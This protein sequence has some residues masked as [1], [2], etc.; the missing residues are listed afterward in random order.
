MAILQWLECL[1][2]SGA[3]IWVVEEMRR[4]ELI[5][6]K[7]E[8]DDEPAS[9]NEKHWKAFC[10]R[11][12]P[13]GKASLFIDG[14]AD[15][16]QDF[17]NF[18]SSADLFVNFSGQWERLEW[19][20]SCPRRVYLD[21]DPAYTQVWAEAYGCDMN[22]KGH[23][24]HLTVGLGL[25][26]KNS[27]IP[28]CGMDWKT[29]PPPACVSLWDRLKEVSNSCL[30]EI[31]SQ[32]LDAWTTITHW[33]GYG[34]VAWNGSALRDKRASLIRLVGLPRMVPESCLGIASDIQ[35][36]W[37]DFEAFETGGWK[38]WSNRLVCDTLENYVAYVSRSRGELG[39]AK[40]GYIITRSG[41][42]SDRSMGYLS[43]GNPVLL[44]DTGWQETY[45]TQK[46][47]V[48]FRDAEDLAEKIREVEDHLPEH[49]LE[50][51]RLAETTFSARAVWEKLWGHVF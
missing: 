49:R 4:D 24:H 1:R 33:H 50:A 21:V 43:C 47:L 14:T 26:P 29:V 30:A 9:L 25:T 17:Q 38:L 13:D 6:E 10:D 22:F 32:S 40:E 15:N 20:M 28:W 36:G 11:W 37:E 31:H 42:M 19:M 46:G 12:I 44:Q 3:E 48:C 18:V 16:I 5:Y 41:W 23:T 51:R 45:P 27:L 2:S 35:S 8:G 7:I 39:I 34:E